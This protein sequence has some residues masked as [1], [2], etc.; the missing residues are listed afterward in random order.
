MCWIMPLLN[1]GFSQELKQQ[2]L[3]MCSVEDDPRI[4]AEA[5]ER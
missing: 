2:D 1:V 4:M 3:Y 5:L